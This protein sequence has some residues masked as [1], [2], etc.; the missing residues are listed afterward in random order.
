MHGRHWH[1]SRSTE[2]TAEGPRLPIA[3]VRPGAV[4]ARARQVDGRAGRGGESTGCSGGMAI[5]VGGRDRVPLAEEA[6][7]MMLP[8]ALAASRTE[9]AQRGHDQQRNLKAVLGLLGQHAA[10]RWRPA[11]RA[12]RGAV[13]A[14]V[15][16]R[17]PGAASASASARCPGRAAGP[18]GDS[19]RCIPGCRCRPACPRCWRPWPARG[20]CSRRCPAACPFPPRCPGSRPRRARAA[21][22]PGPSR[23][24]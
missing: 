14:A 7:R 13:S 20:Q 19:K 24:S 9:A 10:A 17:P 3:R 15:P 21:G 4:G 5:A 11:P 2:K 12:R 8:W 1:A 16:A 18:S 6:G 23:G 22:G